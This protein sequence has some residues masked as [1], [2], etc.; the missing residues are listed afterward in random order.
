[1]AEYVT[2]YSADESEQAVVAALVAPMR[3]RLFGSE[4]ARGS[5]RREAEALFDWLA[6]AKGRIHNAVVMFHVCRHDEGQGF[7]S[8]DRE[9]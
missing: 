4:E 5:S 8:V 6:A 9:G 1:M 3:E 2:G 7:C